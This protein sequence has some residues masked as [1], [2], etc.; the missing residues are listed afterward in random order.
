MK[1]C[2]DFIIRIN[3]NSDSL[4]FKQAVEYMTQS[5]LDVAKKTHPPYLWLLEH[6]HVYTTGASSVHPKEENM[7]HRL[8]APL[9]RT[10]RGGQ[11]TY[12][13][14]GQRVG[15]IITDI[16]QI[17]DG[18]LDIRRFI[19]KIQLVIM[20]TLSEIGVTTCIDPQNVG[21]W[22]KTPLGNKKIAA[23]GIKIHRSG[24]TSYGFAININPDMRYFQHIQPCDMHPDSVIS[25]AQIQH[26]NLLVSFL[27][28]ILVRNF[29]K[30]FNYFNFIMAYES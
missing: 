2:S 12:H 14:P 4:P 20:D 6:E 27:D 18:I 13:G 17:N 24:I 9:E 10:S 23:I 3:G 19:R 5:V 1:S 22:Y 8:P 7:Y 30:H 26:K 16:K 29:I 28:D 15:Y 25:L 21:V 11:L